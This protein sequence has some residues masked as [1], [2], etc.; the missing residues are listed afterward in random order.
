MLTCLGAVVV[1]ESLLGRSSED[2]N[3]GP[4]SPPGQILDFSPKQSKMKQE[5]AR[6]VTGIEQQ[7]PKTAHI[8]WQIVVL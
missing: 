5:R 7:G 3:S 8:N 4:G 2:W 6:K 1:V